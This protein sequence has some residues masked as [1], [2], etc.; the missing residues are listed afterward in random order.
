VSKNLKLLYLFC[1]YNQ[2][3]F[4]TLPTSIIANMCAP[5]SPVFIDK[6]LGTGI[7]LDLSSQL[8]V[9]GN[10]TVYIWKTKSG[11]ALVEGSDY[12]LTDGKTIFLK[13]QADSVYC[14]MT[15]ATFPFF[16]DEKVLKT[17]CTK[18]S[19]N[20][21]IDNANVPVVQIYALNKTLYIVAPYNGQASVYDI[22]GR[23]AMA[24]EITTG[25]NTIA[26]QKSG[27]Y[28]VRLTVSNTPVIKKVF[29]GN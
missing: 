11:T 24:K 22:N 10:T 1:S 15:N 28:L 7:E 8:T 12:S 4:A 16:T 13:S 27:V 5:Q 19:A 29:A 6:A 25:T 26:M 3:T 2:F 18:V 21:G 17:T 20:T 23:L 14:E 9:N